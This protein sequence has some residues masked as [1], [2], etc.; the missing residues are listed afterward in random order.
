MCQRQLRRKIKAGKSTCREIV[1]NKLQ[2]NSVNEVW[3]G[4]GRSLAIS[5]RWPSGEEDQEIA[6]K[7]NLFFDRFST[8]T[9]AQQPPSPALQDASMRTKRRSTGIDGELFALRLHAL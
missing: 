6:N 7:L 3:R 4:Y 1:E 8:G 2:Q 9:P 5:S